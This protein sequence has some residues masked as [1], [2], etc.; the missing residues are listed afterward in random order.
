MSQT[1]A[2]CPTIPDDV[3]TLKQMVAHLLA[4]MQDKDREILN[5]KVQLE[6]LKRRIFG[7]RSE[8]ID[9]NQLALFEDLTRQLEEAV[10]Q[11]ASSQ[12]ATEN[13][14]KSEGNGKKKGH[15]RRPL[16]ADLPRE[17]I[18]V[19][20]AEHDLT[21]PHCQQAKV[22]FSE[23]VTEVLDYV[24]AS[25]I[26]RQYVR[27]EYMCKG[28]EGEF[29]IADLPPQPISRGLPGPGLLA[30]VLT[31]KYADHAPLNR[32]FG[33]F[34]RHD[35]DI[36]VSTMCDWVRDMADLLSPIVV[37]IRRQILQSHRIN[38]DDTP[39][40][41]QN[42][43]GKA[44]GKGYLW[45][46]IGDGVQVLFD[47][48]ASHSRD[49]PLEVLGHYAGYVQADAHSSY[50]AL[51]EPLPDGTPSLRIEVG[52][53]AHTRRKFYDARVDDRQRCTEMLA[54]IR[55]LYDVERE[56]KDADLDPD[57]V[58]ALR[59]EK[60]VPILD[61]IRKR[62]EQWSIE[63]LPKS[64][65]AQAVYYARAQWTALT[66]FLEDGRLGL[67][68]NIAERTL[69]LAAVGRKNY[70]FFGSDAGGH[71]AA[72]IYSLVASCKL[73]GIDPFAYLRDVISIACD[74]TF[75]RFAEITPAAWKAAHPT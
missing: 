24:P 44:C 14:R 22:K 74:P 72:V 19:P 59:L 45:V 25:F 29:T 75:T 54:L 31:S 4:D 42:L 69:R 70:M 1:T 15:G 23:K 56:A 20:P 63:L 46:Y 12:E 6:A 27:P 68:N 65:V 18:E 47:F 7:R 8:K 62:L 33:I 60:S 38:T 16:P 51:F 2:S 67:D 58:R 57:A 64:P 17:R 9:P 50:N 13:D 3:D 43:S 21:C 53:W 48:T 26:V 5:L 41:V 10:A 66:R 11:Q 34:R 52:C 71:R 30:Q 61:E 39:V 49:G 73:V 28:C 36:A 40:L 35:V 37:E 32:Q 55:Q